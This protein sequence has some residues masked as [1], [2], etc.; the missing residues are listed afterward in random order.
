M[1]CNIVK[2]Y[3][4]YDRECIAKY[5]SIITEKKLN[6]KICDMILDVYIDIRYYD[7]YKHVKKHTIDDVYFY[8]Q[9]EYQKK[10][11][12]KNRDRNM[13]LIRRVLVI[14]RYVFLLEKYGK[15]KKI[16]KLLVNFEDRLKEEYHNSKVIISDLI[17][18]IKDDIKKK[19]RF[20][21]NLLSNDFNVSICVTNLAGVYMLD[22][23][24]NVKIPDLFSSIA[25][26]R[27][28][29]SGIINEDKLLVF[30]T[31]TCREILKDM[32][33]YN[34]DKIYIVDFAT[35]LLNKKN[36]LINLFRIFDLDYLKERMVLKITYYDYLDNKDTI[37]GLIH[38]GY[39]FAIILD[40]DYEDNVL[41][42]IFN[43]IIVDDSEKSLQY[44][45]KYKNVIVG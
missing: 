41:L 29:N 5:I 2:E 44:F 28:Y 40:S 12:D 14:L 24:S 19:D 16:A 17:K 33:F 35:E 36:K 20:I 31:L 43:Y 8:I 10:F 13:T 7:I 6:S 34:F 1:A 42:E 11:T 37:D 4:D 27:V 18:N 22:F 26:N 38:D 21:D 39:S 30:Y 45:K 23:D 32:R 9:E 3:I 15:D 25:I